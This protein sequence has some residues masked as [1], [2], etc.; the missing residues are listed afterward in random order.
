MA[1]VMATASRTVRRSRFMSL[2]VVRGAQVDAGGAYSTLWPVFKSKSCQVFGKFPPCSG[3]QARSED[4]HHE[5]L[6]S[7]V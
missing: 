3:V 7:F 5:S 4:V 6:S 1:P 2:S